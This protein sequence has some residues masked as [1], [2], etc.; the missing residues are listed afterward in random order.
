MVAKVPA[1]WCCLG[2]VVAEIDPDRCKGVPTWEGGNMADDRTEPDSEPP[3]LA[4]GNGSR[5]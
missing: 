4:V 3:I 5:A 1:I 2:E